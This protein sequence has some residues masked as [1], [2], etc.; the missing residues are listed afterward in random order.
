M[1]GQIRRGVCGQR[2][3][4]TGVDVSVQCHPLRTP[5]E[6]FEWCV[7]FFRRRDRILSVAKEFRGTRWRF[8]LLPLPREPLGGISESCPGMFM[9][10]PRSVTDG[11]VWSHTHVRLNFSQFRM[12]DS[13]S[14]SL[15][16]PSLLWQRCRFC[17][18]FSSL[19]STTLTKDPL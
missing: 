19:V 6:Y 11:A 3:R 18:S 2:R 14:V 10:C 8:L 12:G 4:W 15:S 9:S 16:I 13:A 5:H 17:A 1:N 7:Q